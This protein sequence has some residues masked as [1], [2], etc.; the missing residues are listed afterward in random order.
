MNL[1]ILTL[2]LPHIQNPTLIQAKTE[3][4]EGNPIEISSNGLLASTQLVRGAPT[5]GGP[6]VEK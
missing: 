4:N 5:P 6:K 3:V 2:T 1:H